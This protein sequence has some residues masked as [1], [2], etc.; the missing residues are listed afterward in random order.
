MF[1]DIALRIY[2]NSCEHIRKNNGIFFTIYLTA[3][4]N[5]LCDCQ[6][7][8]LGHRPDRTFCNSPCSLLRGGQLVMREKVASFVKIPREGYMKDVDRLCK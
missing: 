5:K 8:G 2:P 6:R 7:R 3:E 4:R 1:L